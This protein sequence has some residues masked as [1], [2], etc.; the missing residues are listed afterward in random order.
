LKS[1]FQNKKV[2]ITGSAGSVGSELARLLY[3]L[4]VKKLYLLDNDETRLFDIW[5]ELPKSEPILADI[6]NRDRMKQILR[7]H[8]P[9]IIFHCASYKHVVM[10][11]M[12]PCEMCKTNIDGFFNIVNGMNFT[13]TEK[14]VFISSDKAVNPESVMGLTKA[15]GEK[16]CQIFNKQKKTAFI[17][18]RFANV[19]GSRGSVLPIWEKQLKEGKDLTITD[20]RMERYF[21]DL[22]SACELI[23]KA[24]IMGKGG[25][26]FVLDMGK[27]IKIIEL[28]KKIIKESGKNVGIKIIGKK[29]GEKLREELMTEKEKKLAK[30]V[31]KLWIIKNYA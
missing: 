11:E 31:G 4:K 6:R 9:Q 15:L 29:P 19:L 3:K 27:P 20:K 16:F 17:A 23:L 10:G 28:A 1:F 14:F 24:T 5:E 12:F 21:M 18:V 8:N 22:P 2:L 13:K 30:K 7:K 26:I 25:E